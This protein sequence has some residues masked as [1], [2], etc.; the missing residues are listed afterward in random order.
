M[1]DIIVSSNCIRAK[2]KNKADREIWCSLRNQDL[3]EMV[4]EI[5][6]FLY[7]KINIIFVV[8]L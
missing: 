4:E 2:V 8:V 5:E 3:V 1:D 6:V 7:M